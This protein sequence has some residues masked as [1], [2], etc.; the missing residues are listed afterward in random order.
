MLPAGALRRGA[1][2]R[3]LR[4]VAA[5]CA[6]RCGSARAAAGA[7]AR[8]AHA[9]LPPAQHPAA[10]CGRAAAARAP[11]LQARR[12]ARCSHSCHDLT[13][14]STQVGHARWLPPSPAG[15]AHGCALLHAP[16]PG[17]RAVA[18]SAVGGS[19]ASTAPPAA[20]AAAP[21]AVAAVDTGVLNTTPLVRL[22]APRL[23]SG[24][25]A[26]ARARCTQVAPADETA[27]SA[28]KRALKLTATAGMAREASDAQ[29]ARKRAAQQLD[30]LTKELCAPLSAY[31][32]GFPPPAR[33]HAFERALLDLTVGTAPYERALAR[34]DALRKGIL[35]LGKGHARCAFYLACSRHMPLCG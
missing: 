29:K 19:G 22:R 25:G 9:Q 32:R 4:S 14:S 24:S 3:P 23:R 2:L 15:P 6:P 5:G 30:A 27:R 33:L 12:A 13:H 10:L 18:T 34:I 7:V 16:A 35:E 1:A 28:M 31:V 8:A 17:F 11:L 20:A 26:H 21:S